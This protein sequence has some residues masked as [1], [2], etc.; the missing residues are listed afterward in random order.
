MFFI[1]QLITLGTVLQYLLFIAYNYHGHPW[2]DILREAMRNG[3]KEEEEE[4]EE[5]K[6]EMRKRKDGESSDLEREKLLDPDMTDGGSKNLQDM[7]KNAGG[8]PEVEKEKEEEK[9][10]E[11]EE[12]EGE[13][14]K[15]EKEKE[16]QE[17]E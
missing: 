2:K 14:K 10:K 17:K 16:K 7:R 11:A 13:K 4:R 8:E 6:M 9:E 5:E 12:E 15:E 3:E 1:F